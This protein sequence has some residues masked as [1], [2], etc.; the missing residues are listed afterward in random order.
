M[1]K[2]RIVD[3]HSKRS[4]ACQFNPGEYTVT[5][6]NAWKVTAKTGENLGDVEFGGGKPATLKF[7]LFF[8]TTHDG[9]DV[10]DKTKVLWDMMMVDE[11]NKNPKT[12]VSEPPWCQF[13]WGDTNSFTAVIT[14]IMQKFT[15]FLNDGTPVRATLKVTFQ[16]VKDEKVFPAQN[17]TSRSEAKKIWRVR[18]GQ[19][20][21]WI[22]Y[23]E[24]GDPAQWRHIAETNNLT[25]PRDLR[26][27]QVL[28]LVSLP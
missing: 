3:L 12:N 27:G 21:D 6:K 7:Q 25:N 24:Y 19:T 22:A 17:P 26:P 10:R 28:E 18:E 14:N 11:N 5:K 15:L 9:S 20:L 8:D 23:Q 2:A 13:Q 1:I 4:V 16:Q